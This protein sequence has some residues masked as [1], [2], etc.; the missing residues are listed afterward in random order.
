M[1]LKIEIPLS[2]NFIISSLLRE[3]KSISPS[4]SQSTISSVI[5]LHCSDLSSSRPSLHPEEI[6]SYPLLAF[7]FCHSPYISMLLPLE[8]SLQMHI[9]TAEI[10][11]Q[12]FI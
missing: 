4:I 6:Y 10:H 8:R 2:L 12:K 1:C 9:E 11:L 7:V 3:V 5:R